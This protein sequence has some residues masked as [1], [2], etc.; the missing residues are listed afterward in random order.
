MIA[1]II[2]AVGIT[3]IILSALVPKIA[4]ILTAVKRQA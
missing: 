3:V 2:A 1:Y 4:Q